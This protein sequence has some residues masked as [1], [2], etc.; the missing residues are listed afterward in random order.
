MR[1]TG[2]DLISFNAGI[3]ACEKGA[4]LCKT[5]ETDMSA[6][7]ICFSA[8]IPACDEA[9]KTA[10]VISFSAE[11]SACENG[12]QVQQAFALRLMMRDI[13][14]CEKRQHWQQALALLHQTRESAIADVI[15]LS[16]AIS[17]CEK[18]GQWEQCKKMRETDMIKKKAEKAL[19][20]LCAHIETAQHKFQDDVPAPYPEEFV[21]QWPTTLASFK[22]TGVLA[23][24]LLKAVR[25]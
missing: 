2:A 6:D 25:K 22:A 18:G 23:D 7:V 8:G 14:A 9:G 16:A 17:A 21:P 20:D 19:K 10:H 12:G 5:R 3:S 13:S 1:E 24:G 11:F 15:S 4:L